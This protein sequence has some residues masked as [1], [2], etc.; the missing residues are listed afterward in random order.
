MKIEVLSLLDALLAE[1]EGPDFATPVDYV[2]LG[3]TMYRQMVK[4]PM[5]LGT[6]R[7]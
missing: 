6:I 5:D 7:K 4:A 3:L 1:P 2:A